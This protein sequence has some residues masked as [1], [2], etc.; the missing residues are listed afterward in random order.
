VN[1]TTTATYTSNRDH[2][3]AIVVRGLNRGVGAAAA[4]LASGMKSIMSRGPRGTSSAPG[5]PPNVQG[6]QLWNSMKSTPGRALTAYAGSN[7]PYA[8]I[9]DRAEAYR[10]IIRPRNV[11]MLPVPLGEQGREARRQLGSA[12]VRTLDLVP[13]KSR[14]GNIVLIP[15]G[16]G[17]PL[18][19]LKSYVRL[20]RRPWAMPAVRASARAMLAAFQRE[21]RKSIRGDV[22][23]RAA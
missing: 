12:S 23:G 22:T 18:F 1:V 4:R 8:A 3:K 21:A 15:R 14:A 20:P 19:V 10:R 17:A 13:I 5:T 6:S 16:G 2:Y 11:R 7:L 9:H